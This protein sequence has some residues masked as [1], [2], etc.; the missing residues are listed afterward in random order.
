VI[1]HAYLLNSDLDVAAISEG[2]KRV[3]SHCLWF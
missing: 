1:K 3:T 2:L